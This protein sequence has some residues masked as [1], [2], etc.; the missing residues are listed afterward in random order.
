LIFA[1]KVCGDFAG[2]CQNATQKTGAPFGK[3]FLKS[4]K[5]GIY[6]SNRFGTT[7]VNTKDVNRK[8]SLMDI[9]RHKA[10]TGVFFRFTKYK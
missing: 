8:K 2:S 5:T 1:G 10:K 4:C 7:L 6:Q 9:G 3:V